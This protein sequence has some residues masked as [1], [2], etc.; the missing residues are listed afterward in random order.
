M[1]VRRRAK[2]RA[3]KAWA[4]RFAAPT[5]PVVET[6]TNSLPVD[7]RLWPH[8]VAGSVAHARALVARGGR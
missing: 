3:V 8:D 4:G 1:N 2:A 5:A 6:F 7:R